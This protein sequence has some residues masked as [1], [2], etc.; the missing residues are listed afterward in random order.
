[1][2]RPVYVDIAEFWSNPIRTGIQRVVRQ[3]IA[4]W[5]ADVDRVYVRYDHTTDSLV[6]IPDTILDFLCR[7]SELEG[8][9]PETAAHH[10]LLLHRA[11][12]VRHVEVE[13]A[14]RILIPELFYEAERAAFYARLAA[15]HR[16]E[17]FLTIFDFMPWLKPSLYRL[18]PETSRVI[19]PYARLTML[20]RRRCFISAATRDD[21]VRRI[22][23][24]SDEDVGPVITLGADGL[25]MPRQ[26]FHPSKKD[27]V[28]IG[29]L[30]GKKHQEI[31]FR[32]FLSL[33]RPRNGRLQFLG[34]V[35]RDLAP[36][37]REV[38]EYRGDDIDV[39]DAPTDPVLRAHIALARAS[40]FISS[41]EGFG[42]PAVETLYCGLPTVV[43]AGLPA[44]AG[45]PGAGQLRLS[46][47]T[48]SAVA[49]A[50]SRLDDDHFAAR[51]WAETAEMALPSWR[52]YASTLAQWVRST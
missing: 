14:D 15:E 11:G 24:T 29:T 47:L 10:A 34:R 50:M 5:P 38:V 8:S 4:H 12:G 31:V 9:S 3:V 20:V 13:S 48:P 43:H 39:I 28:C 27:F 18:G 6:E 2:S 25:N 1:M 22:M 23:R 7:E 41:S 21:F 33:P 26:T 30:E 42:L 19:M 16:G 49:E 17:I 32:A 52:D 45:L 44:L 35:P 36:W 40:I 46:E 37:L 51:L